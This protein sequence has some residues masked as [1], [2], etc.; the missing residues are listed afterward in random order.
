VDFTSVVDHL[1]CRLR[2]PNHKSL[3]GSD[4][5]ELVLDTETTVRK[6]EDDSVVGC[7]EL[8]AVV[9]SFSIDPKVHCTAAAEDNRCVVFEVGVLFAGLRLGWDR[10]PS[11]GRTVDTTDSRD[12]VP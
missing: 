3:V 2:E 12:T 8:T 7:N 11:G 10:G 1:N 6:V 5:A 4:V 9:Q